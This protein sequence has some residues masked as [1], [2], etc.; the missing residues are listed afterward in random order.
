VTQPSEIDALPGERRSIS[1]FAAAGWTVA[2][3]LAFAFALQGT[4]AVREGA[5]GDLVSATACCVLA[6]S[7]VV[8]VMLRVYEPESSLRRVLA[9]RK[10]SPFSLI[11]SAL[12]G[13][14]IAPTMHIMGSLIERR[15]P[16][17]LEDLERQGEILTKLLATPTL[18]SKI[19][20]FVAVVFVIPAAEDLFYRGMLFGGLR[21]GRP[22]ALATLITAAY[23][24]LSHEEPRDIPSFFVVGLVFAWLRGQT[25][26]ILPSFLANAAY[27]AMPMI[28]QLLNRA[29]PEE[30][31]PRAVPWGAA[32]AALLAAVGVQLISQRDARAI[33]A[34]REDS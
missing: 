18:T 8:F 17:P 12:V 23:F 22:L 20:L 33:E 11:L 3:Q 24:A 15:F 4:E 19:V 29:S 31:F 21:K 9:L 7:V 32:A 5:M 25:G 14:G 26:S 34:R 6:Y 1:F 13:A 10:V 28:P 16:T 30:L 2:A 27:C